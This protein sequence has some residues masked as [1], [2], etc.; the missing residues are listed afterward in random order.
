VATHTLEGATARA[1]FAPPSAFQVQMTI[2]GS[3]HDDALH[4]LVKIDN[5]SFILLFDTSY[6]GVNII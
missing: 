6:L 2:L 3:N 4:S 5:F 1:Y